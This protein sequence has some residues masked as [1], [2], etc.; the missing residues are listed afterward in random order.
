MVYMVY[1]GI[2]WL[3]ISHHSTAPQAGAPCYLSWLMSRFHCSC[4]GHLVMSKILA[5][6][7]QFTFSI[8]S[9]PESWILNPASWILHPAS[10]I[11]NPESSILI[12]PL[13]VNRLTTFGFA[14]DSTFGMWVL[15]EIW[16][17]DLHL[18]LCSARLKWW[19]RKPQLTLPRSLVLSAWHPLCALKKSS[20]LLVRC[21]LFPFDGLYRRTGDWCWKR[22]T[23]YSK[24]WS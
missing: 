23:R 4:T 15:V 17:S 11:L 21:S 8:P 22:L 10:C 3:V 20:C 16:N 24:R 2:R 7:F 12:A 19:G 9:C 13:R 6:M 14:V 1:F 18:T 5:R